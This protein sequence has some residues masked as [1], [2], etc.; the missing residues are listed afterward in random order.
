MDKKQWRYTNPET[1]ETYLLEKKNGII[2]TID[3]LG[4]KSPSGRLIKL[5]K[6]KN[7]D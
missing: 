2:R 4:Y 1:K 5:E 7:S 3:F 6:G